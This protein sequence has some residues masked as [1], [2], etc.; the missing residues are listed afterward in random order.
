MS[1]ALPFGEILSEQAVGVLVGPPFPGVVRR[2]EVEAA[3]YQYEQ[4]LSQANLYM[5]NSHAAAVEVYRAMRVAHGACV[6]LRGVR[7]DLTF[8]EF[9]R[10]DLT[11]YMTRREVPQGKQEEILERLDTARD[12]GISEMRGY[13]RMLEVQEAERKLGEAQNETFLNELY[14]DDAVIETFNHFFSIMRKWMFHIQFPPGSFQ[15]SD[16]PTNEEMQAALEAVHTALR[17]RLRGKDG[18]AA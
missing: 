13:L 10:D 16:V 5:T 6:N 12:R 15:R 4:R 1:H 17:D 9:N 8:E 7:Q 3:K 18:D 14:F 11:A 2:G